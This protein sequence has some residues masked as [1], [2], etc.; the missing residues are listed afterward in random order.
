[1]D[2]LL[3]A[4]E[5]RGAGLKVL[6][7]KTREIWDQAWTLLLVL[8]LLSIEWILRKRWRLV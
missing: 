5:D 1:M 2:V 3:A 6:D 7:R 8:L 4:F